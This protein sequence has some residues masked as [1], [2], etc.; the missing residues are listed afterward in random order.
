MG[1]FA[2]VVTYTYPTEGV[3]LMWCVIAF[4]QFAVGLACIIT[5]NVPGCMAGAS[6]FMASLA[7]LFIIKKLGDC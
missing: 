2:S 6:W 7:S 1:R 5:P 4:A 3:R